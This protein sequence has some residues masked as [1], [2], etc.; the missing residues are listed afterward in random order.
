MGFKIPN[1]VKQM[2]GSPF[3]MKSPL[4]APT[5][6][7]GKTK[8]YDEAYDALS[9][10]KKAE[11]R[12]SDK[13]GDGKGRERFKKAAKDYNT[14][15]YGTTEPTRDSKKAGK[16]KAELAK[17]V[18]A[19]KVSESSA[20]KPAETKSDKP[21]TK[22]RK[23]MRAE[24]RV[25]RLK[26][27]Q[28]KKGALTPGQQKKLDRNKSKAKG[29][30]VQEKDKTNVGKAIKKGVDK[31]KDVVKKKKD[32]NSMSDADRAAKRK[33]SGKYNADGSPKSAE[34]RNS[35]LSAKG[36]VAKKIDSGEIST[37]K[38]TRQELNKM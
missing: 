11:Y 8:S 34:E 26:K 21:K 15:K 5:G 27:K 9:D 2:S 38:K 1:F 22:T 4:T 29:E 30:K 17:E 31:A 3:A 19:K 35:A 12:K 6:S 20:S 13:A 24:K 33:A 36:S 16:T 14:K 28:E 10:E 32:D 23:Q 25:G 37:G 18:K 7:S